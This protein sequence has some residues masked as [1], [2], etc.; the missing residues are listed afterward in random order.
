[1][2]DDS[3]R[4][5]K[6]VADLVQ[7]AADKGA[8]ASEVLAE[9]QETCTLRSV[10][11][12]ND[13]RWNTGCRLHIRAFCSDGRLGWSVA[14]MENWETGGEA[15]LESALAHAAAVH[16]DRREFRYAGLARLPRSG[17]CRPSVVER[18]EDGN[19]VYAHPDRRRE[20][21]ASLPR[22]GCLP[23]PTYKTGFARR[24]QFPSEQ[25]CKARVLCAWSCWDG[26]VMAPT[27]W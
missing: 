20:P 3:K 2:S 22:L 8:L 10:G 7:M 9:Q 21:R 11:A 16:R 4:M 25:A 17:H 13:V 15:V 19:T 5:Q 14:D 26:K 1:M 27:P 6:C 12:A 24:L 23:R 18:F